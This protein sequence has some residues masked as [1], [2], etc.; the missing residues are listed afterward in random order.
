MNRR[1]ILIIVGIAIVVTGITAF[2]QQHRPYNLVMKDIQPT[3]AALRKNLD[4]NNGAAAAEDAAKLQ[5]LFTEV[6]NFWAPFDT[7]DAVNFAKKAKDAAVSV[8]NAAKANDIKAAQGSIA[9]IQK[10]C[11]NCHLAHREETAKGFLIRP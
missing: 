8:G 4:G 6:E 11:A 7:Q 10:T 2:A 1:S 3:F 5:T 9:V